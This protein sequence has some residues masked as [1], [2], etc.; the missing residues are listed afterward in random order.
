MQTFS[1][2]RRTRLRFGQLVLT[3]SL[4]CSLSLANAATL[5]DDFANFQEVFSTSQPSTGPLAIT[6]TNLSA[7]ARSMQI[8]S[9]GANDSGEMFSELGALSINSDIGTATNTKILYSFVA[10]DLASIANALVFDVASIDGLTQIRIIANQSSEF[11][12]SNIG[13]AGQY[14][15]AFASFSQPGVFSNL[16]QLEL[17]IDSSIDTDLSIDRI[18]AAKNSV[19]EPSS[20]ALLVLGVLAM[21]CYKV[22]AIRTN[23]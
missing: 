2:L 15:A 11:V 10:I 14:F 7:L 6:S 23:F 17:Q 9:T 16:T 3:L 13:L 19:P 21:R 18:A 8:T 4:A 12:L 5:I 1:P 22:Q 20:L